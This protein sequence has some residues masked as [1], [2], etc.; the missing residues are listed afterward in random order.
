MLQQSEAV[1]LEY[2]IPSFPTQ[3]FLFYVINIQN[4]PKWDLIDA[5][6]C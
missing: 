3:M 1:G 2:S 5:S 4:D 6:E